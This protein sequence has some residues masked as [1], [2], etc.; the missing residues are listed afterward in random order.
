[1]AE[2]AG[3]E[4]L[5]PGKQLRS[6]GPHFDLRTGTW[7]MRN[8]EAFVPTEEGSDDSERMAADLNVDDWAGEAEVE[9]QPEGELWGTLE[10]ILL[11]EEPPSPSKVRY[12][13]EPMHA[14]SPAGGKQAVGAA[15]SAPGM[16][17]AK[18]QQSHERGTG[19]DG[20]GL[21]QGGAASSSEGADPTGTPAPAGHSAP[22]DVA[23]PAEA[24][25]SILNGH[26][27]AIGGVPPRPVQEVNIV[28]VQFLT[29]EILAWHTEQQAR[30]YKEPMHNFKKSKAAGYG[31]AGGIPGQGFG[32]GADP[33]SKMAGL[34]GEEQG[35]V[36][37]A[38]RAAVGRRNCSFMAQ[39]SG[40]REPGR[41]VGG[42]IF[43][44]ARRAL[45]IRRQMSNR[46][47]D[48]IR[49]RPATVRVAPTLPKDLVTKSPVD[50]S[51]LS[52]EEMAKEAEKLAREAARRAARRAATRAAA[53]KAAREAEEAETLENERVAQEQ[54]EMD[55]ARVAQVA[56]RAAVAREAAQA[57]RRKRQPI[58]NVDHERSPVRVKKD[59]SGGGGAGGGGGGSA[60]A[61]ASERGIT[62]PTRRGAMPF[63]PPTQRS[64]AGSHAGTQ[65]SQR[66]Q[67]GMQPAPSEKGSIR[68]TPGSSTN[69]MRRKQQV[70]SRRGMQSQSHRVPSSIHEQRSKFSK[71]MSDRQG[72]TAHESGAGKHGRAA[73]AGHAHHHHVHSS[74]PEHAE[75]LSKDSRLNEGGGGGNGSGN[76]SGKHAN[77]GS[78]KS[79]TSVESE[80]A[81]GCTNGSRAHASSGSP[82]GATGGRNGGSSALTPQILMEPSQR[83]SSR[84]WH[85][86]KGATPTRLTISM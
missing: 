62:S 17:G 44:S 85:P 20:D 33:R 30:N 53:L 8:R 43:Q 45:S 60:S 50:R 10:Q 84:S 82:Y 3:N 15:V 68:S 12:A 58:F 80:M 36:D 71:A 47:H 6:F 21:H 59:S 38:E 22:P 5:P 26:G 4:K 9:W 40:R 63:D 77:G 78:T 76:G 11:P 61:P 35:P 25:V 14:S 37:D 31:F 54:L 42:V 41:H 13:R 55:A 2:A 70:A 69:V 57:A 48:T 65:R 16:A 83:A 51:K 18:G 24:P 46:D 64:T 28:Q 72:S 34:H 74:V 81:T 75:H 86:S 23:P 67:M 27:K 1:M 39:Q 7:T 56:R 73:S 66:S 19:T 79:T 52:K 49:R 32:G 29:Q